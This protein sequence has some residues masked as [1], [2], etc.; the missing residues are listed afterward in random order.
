MTG[1]WLKCIERSSQHFLSHQSDMAKFRRIF[2][3][4]KYFHMSILEMIGPR[5]SA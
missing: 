1:I 2:F 5:L 3:P 4:V